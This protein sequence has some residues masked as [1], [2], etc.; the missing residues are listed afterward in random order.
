MSSI[1][2]TA[3]D[4]GRCIE[5]DLC[6]AYIQPSGDRVDIDRHVLG[7]YMH[8]LQSSHTYVWQNTHTRMCPRGEEQV[9]QVERVCTCPQREEL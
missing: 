5:C 1:N 6:S 7:V 4:W 3:G 8:A 9:G 2:V